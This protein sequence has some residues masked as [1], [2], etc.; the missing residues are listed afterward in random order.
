MVKPLWSRFGQ[1][2]NSRSNPSAVVVRSWTSCEFCSHRRRRHT[3][4]LSSWVAS[5]VCAEFATSWRQS[6]RRVWTNLPTAKSSCVVL[7]VWTH[8]SAV[9]TPVGLLLSYWGWWQ[10][11][12]HSDVIV[13]KVINIDHN[14]RSQT[15]MES[16]WPV[17]KSV[18]ICSRR[19]LV[20]NSVHTADADATQLDSWVASA[21]AL[22]SEL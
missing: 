2:P 9:V 3:T 6:R 19:E 10:K 7:E 14:S 8:P 15:A 16:V 1:F 20:T 12:R 22:C 13:E 5:M 18:G 11:W 4:Q 21:S 17:S